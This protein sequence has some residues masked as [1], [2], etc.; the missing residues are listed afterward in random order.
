M[1]LFNRFLF[2]GI[3]AVLALTLISA[4]P[5]T[6]AGGTIEKQEYGTTAGGAA[7]DEYTLTNT[8]GMEVK[9]IN[10]G[11][12]I[13]SVKVPDRNGNMADVVLGFSTLED[14]ETLN[15]PYFGAIIGRYGNRIANGMFTIDGQT[16][17]LDTNN[18]PNSLHGGFV[19]FDKEVWEV[20]EATAGEDGVVLQL[21]YLSA[22]GEG[23][24]PEQDMV[25]PDCPA[26][27]EKGY[28]GTLDVTVVYTLTDQNEI[29]IGYT[30]TTDAPTI[31]NLTN[32]SYWNLAG[33]GLGTIYDHIL[34]LN[35]DQFTPDDETL[36]PTGELA[37]VEGTPF[38]F[39][40]PKTIG[41]GARSDDPQIVIGRGYDH[42]WVL[43]RPSETDTSMMLAARLYEPGSGRI[44]EVW[45]DQP[46]IQY[47]GGNFLDGTLYGP[48][49]HSY[50][51]GDG[52]ALETQH[53]PDSPNHS[54]FPSTE[55]TPGETYHT[56]TIF[57][58]LTD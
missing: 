47:Y 21:H 4:V 45:T 8:N 30:A 7:V 16:Y 29:Q 28:P 40:V 41:P 13:T 34:M 57:K 14:Y 6:A 52:L 56:M 54:N 18:G 27:A 1:K 26:D 55:L 43:A 17:C 39:R 2:V 25:S 24:D 11:G 32:H 44:L 38:D 36:I 10:Y 50:R 49:G 48:S 58:L 31:V 9:I 15:S 46:G 3:T 35:A 51:Q 22:A 53:F 20:Q 37:P 19:G 33:E 5:M 12:I 23:Y 42:N